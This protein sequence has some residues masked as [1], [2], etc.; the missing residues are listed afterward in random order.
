[1]LVTLL[2]QLTHAQNEPHRRIAPAT[3]GSCIHWV[4]VGSFSYLQ[5]SVRQAPG[6]MCGARETLEESRVGK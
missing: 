3:P 6:R 1:M 5:A 4:P 2:D